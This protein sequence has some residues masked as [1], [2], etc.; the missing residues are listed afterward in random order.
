ME[1]SLEIEINEKG[2]NNL[3]KIKLINEQVIFAKDLFVQMDSVRYCNLEDSSYSVLSLRFVKEIRFVHHLEG[4]MFGLIAGGLL[5]KVL[6]SIKANNTPEGSM[7]YIVEI[8]TIGG[9]ILGTVFGGTTGIHRYYEFE[10]S[11]K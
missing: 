2:K 11:K 4:A 6:G 10:T 8:Y 3:A 1:T 7:T 5:G 9:I